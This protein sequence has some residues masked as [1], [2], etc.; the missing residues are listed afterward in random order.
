MAEPPLCSFADIYHMTL[1]DVARM[2]DILDLKGH[3][4]EKQREQDNTQPL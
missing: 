2:H 1:M 3:L 4:Y